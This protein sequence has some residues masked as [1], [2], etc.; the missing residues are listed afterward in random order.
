MLSRRHLLASCLATAVF[1]A[2]PL[3]FASERIDYSPAAF[4]A[5]QKA[6]R[7]ILI[8]IH[9][10]WCPTC[11]AQAP[12]LS[13][14][15]KDAKFKDLLVVHV[16]FDSQK[17]A[18]RRPALA[19]R[20]RSS[21]SRGGRDSRSV[22]DTKPGVDRRAARQIPLKARHEPRDFGLAFLAGLLSVLSFV[23]PLVPIVLGAAASEHR[24]GPAA[25]AAVTAS[26]VAIGL[27]VA[28]VGFPWDSTAI[29]FAPRARS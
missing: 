13:E 27:F 4:D 23:L 16:D 11:R 6:G 19:C 9:A 20:A 28:T 7:S 1:V 17:D 10:P 26:F 14:L 24:F 29:G 15:E 8:E 5:A 2:A 22:G 3:A 18:V 12:I 21:R 25:L